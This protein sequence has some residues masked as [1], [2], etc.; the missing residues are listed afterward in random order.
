MSENLLAASMLCEESINSINDAEQ[1]LFRLANQLRRQGETEKAEI[2]SKALMKLRSFSARSVKALDGL[3][4]DLLINERR[5]NG[6]ENNGAAPVPE[7]AG[8]SRGKRAG[9]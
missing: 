6:A 1:H 4:T 9:A 2:A 8:P 3:L 5:T 7:T